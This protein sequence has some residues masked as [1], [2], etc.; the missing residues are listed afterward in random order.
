[1]SDDGDVM[2]MGWHEVAALRDSRTTVCRLPWVIRSGGSAG[3]RLVFGPASAV[4]A[5]ALPVNMVSGIAGFQGQGNR[6]RTQS[7]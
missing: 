3:R 5:A 6:M 7:L 1:M 2:S 4:R